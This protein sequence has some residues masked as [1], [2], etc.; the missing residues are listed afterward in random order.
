MIVAGFN[1]YRVFYLIPPLETVFQ[2]LVIAVDDVEARELVPGQFKIELVENDISLVI[3]K[4]AIPP[5]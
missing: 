4:K 5:Q 3:S 1:L 2:R